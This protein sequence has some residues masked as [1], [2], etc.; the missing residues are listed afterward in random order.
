MYILDSKGHTK[1]CDVPIVDE[2]T[3]VPT[4][5]MLGENSGKNAAH[6]D[7]GPSSVGPTTEKSI[8]K[9]AEKNPE[10][11]TKCFSVTM[12]SIPYLIDLTCRAFM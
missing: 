12:E 8:G 3:V 10:E 2:S 11:C 4:V 6:I 9:L 7:I 1:N 5:S